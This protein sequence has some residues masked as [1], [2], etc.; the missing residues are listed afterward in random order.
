MKMF[1]DL[2]LGD[3]LVDLPVVRC[4]GPGYRRLYLFQHKEFPALARSQVLLTVR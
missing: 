2:K 1:I 3:S 4:P